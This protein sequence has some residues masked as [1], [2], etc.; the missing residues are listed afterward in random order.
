M[1]SIGY[2]EPAFRRKEEEGKEYIFDTLRRKW[3]LLTPEEWVRQNFINY[4]VQ[5]MAY[6]VSLIA[7]EKLIRLG[8]MNKRF[9]ILVYDRTHQPWLMVECKAPEVPL[10]DN[11]LQQILRYNLSVPVAYLVITNGNTC[12]AWHRGTAG[13]VPLA[14]LPVH[15]G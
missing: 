12:Y 2:P 3:L 4:L 15:G 8:E 11:T 5:V 1:I 13:L 10:T 7:Q 9:D 6:P 14:E